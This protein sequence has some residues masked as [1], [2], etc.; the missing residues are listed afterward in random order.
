M[1]T[2]LVATA[3]VAAATVLL[4]ASVAGCGSNS[5]TSESVAST[6]SHSSQSTSTHAQ[7]TDYTRL[8]IRA[9]DIN[10]PEAFT[11]TPPT[12]NPDGKEGVAM[13]FSNE[14]G[15]HVIIDTILVLPD[16]AAAA[17]AH[18]AAKATLSGSTTGK[19]VQIDIGTGGTTVSGESPDGSKGVTVLRF[20]EGR[21]FATLEFDGPVSALAPPEFVTD[22]G[23]KQDA[24]IKSGLA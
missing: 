14:D 16:P 6:T 24:A 12:R 11:A 23:Q 5:K 2:S 15:S 4:G 18:N 20:T 17:A 3:G 21:A 13:T 1:R 8:L 7:P 22:V 9:E 19:P 10:A